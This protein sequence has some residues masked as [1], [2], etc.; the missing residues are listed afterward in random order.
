MD[1]EKKESQLGVIFKFE[2]LGYL[3]DKTFITMTVI[4]VALVVIVGAFS[5]VPRKGGAGKPAVYM[6]G[7]NAL[8]AGLSK[9]MTPEF[10]AE[11]LGDTYE[12]TY[13]E[14]PRDIQTMLRFS[15]Y[16]V[17]FCYDGGDTYDLYAKGLSLREMGL[18]LSMDKMVEKLYKAK[19]LA[20]FTPEQRQAAKILDG[21]VITP[22]I[23]DLG[24]KSSSNFWVS[25]ILLFLLYITISAHNQFIVS[26]VVTE[27]TSRA[28]ELLITSA[29][30]R[31]L[32]FGKVFGVAAAAL[33]QFLLIFLAAVPFALAALKNN[34]LANAKTESAFILESF[35]RT[36]T[37]PF[38]VFCF[39]MFFLLGYF[40]YAFFYAA[41]ASTVSRLEEVASV[42]AFPMLFL[43]AG[44]FSAIF[45]SV[46]DIN[47]VFIK[48]LSYIP[49]FSPMVMFARQCMGAAQ[50]WEILLAIVINIGGVAL[51][52]IIGAKIY[53]AGVTL[54][55]R[56]LKFG[57]I[58]NIIKS[59]V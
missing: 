25:Y 17:A 29:K 10:M 42:A 23:T 34:L 4:L 1:N 57:D 55:G 22:V 16:S 14:K 11:Q 59:A 33:T 38:F 2:Y 37:S 5:V 41:A 15:K 58:A 13:T 43:I 53:R 56:K 40:I 47:S 20:A 6:L 48:V 49:L 30:P 32:M 24:G 51:M 46:L 27:K 3:K 39:I 8:A 28:M 31:N 50:V 9:T 36:F 54:Y 12:W 19:L 52:G 45:G 35:A 21:V 26:S 18:T 7:Q 44:F